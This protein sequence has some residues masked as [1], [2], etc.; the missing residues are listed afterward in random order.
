MQIRKKLQMLRTILR[1]TYFIIHNFLGSTTTGSQTT[2]SRQLVLRQLA[3]DNWFT[4]TCSRQL[5][6]D[7]W[8]TTIG[9]RQLVNDNWFIT[10]GLRI[11]LYQIQLLEIDSYNFIGRI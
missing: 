3:H 10:L 6:H 1:S 8:F 7:N 5:A 9:S 4:T 2:C 11:Y